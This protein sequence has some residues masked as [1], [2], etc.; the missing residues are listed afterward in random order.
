[1]AVVVQFKVVVP[2]LL[3]IPAVGNELTVKLTVCVFVHPDA[4]VPVTVYIVVTVGETATVDPVDELGFHVYV[5]APVA[6]NDED[7]PTQI[8]DDDAVAVNVGKELTVTLT[9]CVFVI[10][11]AF[12][13]VTV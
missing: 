7:D 5:V 2:V 4:F 13:P 11:A 3:V 1:M 6:V 9:V 8:A 12:A 10:P